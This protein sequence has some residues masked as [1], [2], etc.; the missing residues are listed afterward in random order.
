MINCI[1]LT[2]GYAESRQPCVVFFSSQVEYENVEQAAKSLL[3]SLYVAYRNAF[4]EDGVRYN[5]DKCEPCSLSGVKFC[6]DCGTNLTPKKFRFNKFEDFVLTLPVR[7]CDGM[8]MFELDEWEMWYADFESAIRRGTY[9]EIDT[10]D[11]CESKPPLFKYLTTDIVL[12]A[13]VDA[14]N[15]WRGW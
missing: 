3:A 6:S 5:C 2:F 11:S 1:G 14:L 4:Y 12:P 10:W 15:E 7:T 8:G 13:D 9:A